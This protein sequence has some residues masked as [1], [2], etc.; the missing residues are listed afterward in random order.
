[1]DWQKSVKKIRKYVG[2]HPAEGR[3]VLNWN[4]TVKMASVKL[5]LVNLHHL[6]L[7]KPRLCAVAEDKE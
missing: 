3:G 1:L 2:R 6:S 4:L 7:S 5:V